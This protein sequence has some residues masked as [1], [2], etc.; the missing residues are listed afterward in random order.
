MGKNISEGLLGLLQTNRVVVH[1]GGYYFVCPI[2]FLFKPSLLFDRDYN[3]NYIEEKFGYLSKKYHVSLMIL[4]S[5]SSY[6]T[7]NGQNLTE[8]I[9]LIIEEKFNYLSKKYHVKFNDIT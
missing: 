4:R 6:F 1:N 3:A 7:E 5:T 8:I 9:M 2:S